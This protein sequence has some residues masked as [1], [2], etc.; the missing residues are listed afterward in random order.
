MKCK[1]QV[2]DFLIEYNIRDLPVNFL[3]DHNL[4][5]GDLCDSCKALKT[6]VYDTQHPKVSD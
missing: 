1:F 4:V 5:G 3:I 6:G 2:R